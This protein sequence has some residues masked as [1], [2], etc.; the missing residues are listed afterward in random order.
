MTHN[1]ESK[2][3]GFSHETGHI[4]YSQCKDCGIMTNN[5]GHGE[6]G[7]KIFRSNSHGELFHLEQYFH[8][9][10]LAQEDKV[11][12]EQFPKIFK[13]IVDQ[14]NEKWERPQS[15]YQHIITILKN[16]LQTNE[17]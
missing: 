3:A 9:A 13:D 2:V 5:Y 8:L 12:K 7:D 16:N 1:F 10:K 4:N 6:F 14:A 17:R 15:V 11:F